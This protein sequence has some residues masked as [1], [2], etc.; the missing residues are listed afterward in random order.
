MGLHCKNVWMNILLLLVCNYPDKSTFNF[1]MLR[2]TLARSDWSVTNTRALSGG[3]LL[4]LLA[5][6]L[7]PQRI[8]DKRRESALFPGAPLSPA[9]CD[10]PVFM[11]EGLDSHH[12]ASA[13]ATLKL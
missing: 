11:P 6:P 2:L 13:H 4:S 10:N 9:L 8:E 5:W 12:D 3:M 1:I 7:D